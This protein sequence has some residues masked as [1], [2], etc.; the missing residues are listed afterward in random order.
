MNRSQRTL[1]VLTLLL[2]LALIA[3][4]AA[5]SIAY[6]RSLRA[7]KQSDELITEPTSSERYETSVRALNAENT[8]RRIRDIRKPAAPPLAGAAM[9]AFML[10]LLAGRRRLLEAQRD[11]SLAEQRITALTQERANEP[12]LDAEREALAERSQ[13][14][15]L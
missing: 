11:L 7:T 6:D 2:L 5:E 13:E 8:W 9:L 3:L 15:E 12:K 1:A 4:T 14:K 10:T